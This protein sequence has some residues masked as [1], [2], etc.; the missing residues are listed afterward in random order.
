MMANIL[1][2]T[3]ANRLD[4]LESMPAAQAARL[5]HATLAV[6]VLTTVEWYS[7]LLVEW[8][9]FAEMCGGRWDCPPVGLVLSFVDWLKE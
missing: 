3:V 5:C 6:L 9:Q 1:R 7:K 2:H 8:Q 4:L